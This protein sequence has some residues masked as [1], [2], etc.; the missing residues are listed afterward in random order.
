MKVN[1]SPQRHR[2]RRERRFRIFLFA[3]L[4]EANKINKYLCALCGSVVNMYH[5]WCL[6][7]EGLSYYNGRS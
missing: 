6:M 4:S 7:P 3:A 2:V 5:S 1:S